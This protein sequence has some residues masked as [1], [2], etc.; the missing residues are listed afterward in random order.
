MASVTLDSSLILL[1][2]AESILIDADHLLSALDFAVEGRL[3]HSASFAIAAALVN[4]MV[5][6]VTL[7]AVSTHLGYDVFAGNG[8]F[9]LL[10]PFTTTS[11]SF[12]TWT[13]VPL[14]SMVVLLCAMV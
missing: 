8:L 4:K 12:P 10:A 5:F 1:A 14:E 6:L 11:Y 2:G 9:P 7:A 13:R 3:A